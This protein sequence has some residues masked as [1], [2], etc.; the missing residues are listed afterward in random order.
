MCATGGAGTCGV[1]EQAASV[2][3]AAAQRDARLGPNASQRL[4]DAARVE[5]HLRPEADR[6]KVWRR[7]EAARDEPVGEQ[8]RAVGGSF[9]EGGRRG[10]PAH[11]EVLR[12]QEA[13]RG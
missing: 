12:R 5:G 4:D 2:A 9:G 10:R 11:E 8:K 1:C 7:H 6:R 3:S 13:Q